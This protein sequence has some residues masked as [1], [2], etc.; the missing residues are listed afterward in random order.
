MASPFSGRAGRLAGMWAAN[1]ATQGMGQI[2]GT[3]LDAQNAA[4]GY[5]TTGY[6]V[7][8]DAL[9]TGY[10]DMLDNLQAAYGAAPGQLTAGRDAGVAALGGGGASALNSLAYGRDFGASS[11]NAGRDA[12]LIQSTIGRDIAGG[13]YDQALNQT[14][15]NYAAGRGAL[16]AGFGSAID[17]LKGAAGAY[18]PLISE[19]MK[20]YQMYG[21][22]LGLGGAEG[23]AAAKGAF[24]AGPGYGWQVE[25]ATD[26]A[27][28]A[29]NRVGGLYGGNTI[30][31]TTR[32][33]SNLANQE[34]QNW[35]KNLSPYQ[36]A[37]LQATTGKATQLDQLGQTY[38][39]QGT[40]LAGL[41][42]NE[43]TALSNLYGKSA[44]VYTGAGRDMANLYGQTGQQLSNLYSTSGKAISDIQ[45]GTAQDVAG[46]EAKTGAALSG[47]TVDEGSQYAKLAGDYATGIAGLAGNYGGSMAGLITGTAG[48]IAAAQQAAN[49]TI[50]QSGT[51]ALLAGQQASQNTW[52]AALGLLGAGTKLL[53]TSLGSS[54]S[55]TLLGS[56]F[57]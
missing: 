23:N 16:N 42:Q 15:S 37:A 39:M 38:G 8:R 28:R 3:L 34:Y 33:G 41:E 44:D 46:L 4:G 20:G 2:S 56:L 7:S 9:G 10:V 32:L 1:Q 47:L 26:A 31:A 48:N 12:G 49:N 50:T 22:A 17:T 11:L 30:D 55:P 27:Q 14:R 51:N 24:Q 5:L 54:S 40:A 19:G 52:G 6:D 45:R 25:Q 53:G 35:I 29:A 36:Q 21:N 43:A 18:D 57:K 13:Q